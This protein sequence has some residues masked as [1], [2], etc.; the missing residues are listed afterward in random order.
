MDYSSSLL[1]LISLAGH[2]PVE[3][4]SYPRISGRGVFAELRI[5]GRGKFAKLRINGRTNRPKV[6]LQQGFQECSCSYL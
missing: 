5:K 6:P 4:R 1:G 3:G 2:N